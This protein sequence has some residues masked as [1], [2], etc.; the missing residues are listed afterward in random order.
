MI[1]ISGYIAIAAMDIARRNRER[2]EEEQQEEEEK[3]EEE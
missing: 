3:E 1:P 2:I